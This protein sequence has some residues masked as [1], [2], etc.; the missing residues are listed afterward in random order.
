MYGY[1]SQG[2]PTGSAEAALAPARPA[3]SATGGSLEGHGDTHKA[4]NTVTHG[5]TAQKPL[6][7]KSALLL[8]NKLEKTKLSER[9]LLN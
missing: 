6:S 5:Q 7:I 3:L 8:K 4:Q 2:C 9:L 1:L